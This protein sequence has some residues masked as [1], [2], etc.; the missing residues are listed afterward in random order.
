LRALR[1][2]QPRITVETEFGT[3]AGEL[4]LIGN[5]QRYGG[6]F[7]LF[8]QA[9]LQDGHLDAHVYARADTRLAMACLAGLLT[10]RLGQVGRPHRIRTSSLRLTASVRTPF[11]ID[12]ELAGY[13][14]AELEVCAA[15]LRVVVPS[16]SLLRGYPLTTEAVSKGL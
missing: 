11:Q 15:A 13:L 14:P 12:G 7:R 1:E 9:D 2:A 16:A 8:P 6:S 4:V 5:G 10:G 3:A